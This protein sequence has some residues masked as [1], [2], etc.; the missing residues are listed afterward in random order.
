MKRIFIFGILIVSCLISV[1]KLRASAQST[2]RIANLPSQSAPTPVPT[3]II[4]ATAELPTQSS[5][6][7]SP[8]LTATELVTA[9][10]VHIV[11]AGDTLL[12]IASDYRVT[13][14]QLAE[15]NGIADPNLIQ[16]G[17]KLVIPGQ[18]R[19]VE[20]V[21]ESE[22][23]V[24][25]DAAPT[26]IPL[27]T[28]AGIVERMTEAAQSVPASN[29]FYR[30]TWLTYYGRPNVPVMGILG[31]HNIAD[32][33]TLLQ[34]KA[35]SYDA[36]NGSELGIVPAFHL[37]YG[38]ATWAPGP[39]GSYLGF[40][41]DSQVT[42][43][44]SAAIESNFQVILDIQIGGL[45]PAAALEFGLPWLK[46]GNVHLAL[47][48]EFALVYPGQTVPGN[49]AGY[50]TAAQ[51]NEAQ[52]TMQ[53]YIQKNQIKG[54]R[55][56]LLHQFLDTMIVNKADLA[57]DFAGIELVI[58]VDGWGPPA[59]KVSKYNQFTDETVHFSSFKLFYRWDEPLMSERE[60]LG[61]DSINGYD[62]MN[63]TP[64]MI[65]YQ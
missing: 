54:K 5:V 15:A 22:Q 25:A 42:E 13:I 48:P 59:G 12:G 8:S 17:Q 64:N 1:G 2:V 27:P 21:V 31:E 43:Y 34:E 29:P 51:I 23:N 57:H 45:T 49:P 3:Q 39:D 28:R 18:S 6:A 26:E 20:S 41:P 55:V 37:V 10:L 53:R 4:T 30:K 19:P 46:Y 52:A 50:V 61:V 62:Y 32:L 44:I 47:D 56:L 33:T 65:I 14:N 11:V 16:V 9:P 35:D 40:M 38:M 60:A 63:V 7:S 36:A 24:G 58:S